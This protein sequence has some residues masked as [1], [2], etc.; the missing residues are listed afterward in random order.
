MYAQYWVL[1]VWYEFLQLDTDST[2]LWVRHLAMGSSSSTLGLIVRVLVK[3]AWF[4]IALGYL[5]RWLCLGV[6]GFSY[7]GYRSCEWWG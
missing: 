2:R 3:V 5:A 7:G 6:W 4:N 1:G